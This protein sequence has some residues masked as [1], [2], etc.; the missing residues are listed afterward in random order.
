MY[1]TC[2]TCIRHTH[3]PH[4]YAALMCGSTYFKLG[5]ACNRH[6][7]QVMRFTRAY[8][9]EPEPSIYTPNVALF[10]DSPQIT[11]CPRILKPK[12]IS[13]SI[14]PDLYYK[15]LPSLKLE[16]RI[17][18]CKPQIRFQTPTAPTNALTHLARK[19]RIFCDYNFI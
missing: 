12:T 17:P 14:P 13:L 18:L 6:P 9:P 7:H 11:G 4:I 15:C 10:H 8:V 3:A 2:T 16:V 19:T 1:Y 5:S